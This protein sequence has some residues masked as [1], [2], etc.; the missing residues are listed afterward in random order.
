VGKMMRNRIRSVV[1]DHVHVDLAP[2]DPGKGRA[3]FRER[4]GSPIPMSQR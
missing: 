3:I 2:Y 4:T 1:G